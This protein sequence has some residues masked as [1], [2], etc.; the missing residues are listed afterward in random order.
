MFIWKVKQAIQKIALNV[1]TNYQNGL[2][3]LYLVGKYNDFAWFKQ[4]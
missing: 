2:I 1:Y 4:T 3:Y